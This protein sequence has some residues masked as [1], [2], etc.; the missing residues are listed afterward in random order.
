M[1]KKV[2]MGALILGAAQVM[3]AAPALAADEVSWTLYPAQLRTGD[4]IMAETFAGLSGCS[5]AGPVT[6]PGLAAPLQWTEGGNFGR[7]GGH[8]T[9]GPIPGQ[10]T[11]T[12]T[13]SDGRIAAKALTVIGR[14]PAH[15]GS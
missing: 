12:F 2:L 8:G 7:Y 10:Y 5:P 4:S 6:S 1:L 13:C 9:A 15:P 11:A 14:I 3:V